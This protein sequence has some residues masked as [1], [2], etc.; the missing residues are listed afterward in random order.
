MIEILSITSSKQWIHSWVWSAKA[1]SLAAASF[2][3]DASVSVQQM[4]LDCSASAQCLLSFLSSA[5]FSYHKHTVLKMDEAFLRVN[6]ELDTEVVVS[7]MSER[8]YQVSYTLLQWWLSAW[9]VLMIMIV[10]L[11]RSRCL[12][13]CL[14]VFVP[15]A[16]GSP[17]WAQSW[18]A[19]FR[20]IH[21]EHST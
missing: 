1:T 16:G 4:D 19:Q 6:N 12:F 21:C 5:G 9:F 7:W 20:R 18:S 11:F 3:H 14:L 10:L 2:L 15:A 8:C 17:C 13:L